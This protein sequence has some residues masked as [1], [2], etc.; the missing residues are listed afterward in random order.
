LEEHGPLDGR[1]LRLR[2]LRGEKNECRDGGQNKD[3]T[4]VHLAL[5]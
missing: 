2:D 5:S 3:A 4:L 1:L